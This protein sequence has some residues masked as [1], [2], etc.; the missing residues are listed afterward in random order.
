[1]IVITLIKF[2]GMKSTFT[3]LGLA[4]TAVVLLFSAYAFAGPKPQQNEGYRVD[5]NAGSSLTLFKLFTIQPSKKSAPS[6]NGRPK[7]AVNKPE[8]IDKREDA[9][10][11]FPVQDRIRR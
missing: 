6:G 3:P 8:T 4:F 2:S 1:L 10:F 11:S 5:V 7:T 9:I